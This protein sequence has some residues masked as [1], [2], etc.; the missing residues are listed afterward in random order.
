M[1]ALVCLALAACADP[2]VDVDAT[3]TGVISVSCARGWL[4]LDCVIRNDGTRRVEL[5]AM[6]DLLDKHDVPVRRIPFVIELSPG[7]QTSQ[8][9]IA[10]FSTTSV[11]SVRVSVVH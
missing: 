7:Q 8:R 11:V 4:N 10:S 9:L 3:L 6:A 2:R 5:T 1:T